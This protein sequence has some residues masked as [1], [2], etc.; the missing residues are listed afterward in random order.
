LEGPLKCGIIAALQN[1]QTG[2]ASADMKVTTERLEN[3][4]V[5]VI[6]EMD[7]ADI[8]KQLRQTARMISRSYNVPGYRRGKAPYHA[9][10][11]I[12]GREAVQQQ[13][14]ESY[15]QEIY[16][17]ALEEVEFEP[18]EI[19]ELQEVE[20]DPFRMTILLPI[21]PEVDLG[22][23]RAVRV[24]HEPEPVSEED[25]QQRLEDLQREN[26]QWVPV[27]R[28]AAFGDEVVLDFE[29]KVG[30]ELIMSQEEHE[31]VLEAESSLPIAGFHEEIVGVAPG[32]TKTFTL[33]V[34]EGDVEGD[35]VGEEA[36]VTAT[37]HTVREEDLPP[38]DDELAMMVGDY[39]TLDDLRAS[40]RE[41]LESAARDQAESEYLDKVLDAMI[42]SAVK[43]EYP[44]QAVDRETDLALSQMER[45]L[46]AQGI[47]LDTF[48]NMIGKTREAYR[49]DM[50][51]S[52]EERL[53][54]RLVLNEI[55]QLEGLEAD[56]EELDAQIERLAAMAGPS[57][58]EMREML[59]SPEGRQSIADDLVIEQAQELVT[60]IGKGEAPPP[61]EEA[62]E[63]ALEAEEGVEPA[64]GAE[65]TE[66]PAAETLPQEEA[67]TEAEEQEADE[68]A[69]EEESD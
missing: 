7:A 44:P 37:L 36:T 52:A 57:S 50:R 30:D 21:Q 8:D 45:S 19:G 14:L 40:I 65:G 60:Q 47:Q 69:E 9:V 2:E 41:E 17:E 11:R 64:S 29:A 48:L 31:M 16:E 35:L 51:P 20:W 24:P 34:P 68:V 61:E 1:E 56:A 62:E 5:N 67:G 6:V 33:T 28:P 22:D 59:E 54:K 12:F 46:A 55:A 27:E 39:D 43:L 13:M 66:E 23:Y 18:Y 63:E 15:G 53:Q 49:E 32:E 26:G 25:V 38:L 10:V 3:C 58:D 42:E 4:Q